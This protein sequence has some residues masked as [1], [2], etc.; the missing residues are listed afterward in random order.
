[1]T[2][3]TMTDVFDL[4]QK[5]WTFEAKPSAVLLKTDLPL[6]AAAREAAQK[7]RSVPISHDAQYWAKKT[8]GFDF[9]GEDRVDADLFN[10]IVWEG[11][12]R[13]PYPARD[14]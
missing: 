7:G 9:S 14:Y 12:M 3:P 8:A 4:N 6:P 11:L 13:G 10:R 2:T 5:E 1:A